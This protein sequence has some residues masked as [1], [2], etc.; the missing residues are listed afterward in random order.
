MSVPQSDW[1]LIARYTE[2]E[3]NEREE[4]YREDERREINRLKGG[5]E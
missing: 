2:E 4:D 3:E 5:R 1:D